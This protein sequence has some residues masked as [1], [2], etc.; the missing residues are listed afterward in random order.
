MVLFMKRIRDF[1]LRSPHGGQQRRH[2]ISR[3]RHPI[4]IRAPKRKESPAGYSGSPVYGISIHAPRTESD[5]ISVSAISMTRHFNPRP[6][7]GGRQCSC[8]FDLP[9]RSISI[10][11]LLTESDI[12]WRHRGCTT[13]SFQSTPSAWRATNALNIGAVF[14]YI[15]QSTL[16]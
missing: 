4:S 9:A 1:Y 14:L 10:H 2:A 6:L 12:V 11:A 15:F 7:H 3:L 5:T 16:S 8:R 13:I